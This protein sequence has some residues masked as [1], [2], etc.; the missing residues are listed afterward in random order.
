MLGWIRKP[1][2]FTVFQSGETVSRSDPQ[3]A[4]ACTQKVVEAAERRSDWRE[5][6]RNKCHSVEAQQTIRCTEPEVTIQSLC[7][8]GSNLDSILNSP[9]GMRV[10]G[11]LPVGIDCPDR[12]YVNDKEEQN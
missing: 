9:R 4:I 10:L 11:D 8:G 6:V 12:S 2:Q 1:L 3:T 7:Y 5:I